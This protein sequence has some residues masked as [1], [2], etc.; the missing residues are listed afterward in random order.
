MCGF[1]QMPH[2][3]LVDSVVQAISYIIRR[4][5]GLAG[6]FDP[7]AV[8]EAVT[9]AAA[10]T[11]PVEKPAPS[12]QQQFMQPPSKRSFSWGGDEGASREV[13]TI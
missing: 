8:A 1:G 4:W 13:S 10:A 7:T 9:Q 11:K 6:L 3:D 5:R 12:V 2:D